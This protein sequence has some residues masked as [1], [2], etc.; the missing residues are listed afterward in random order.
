MRDPF[1]TEMLAQ[2]FELPEPNFLL[3][4]QSL[5]WHNGRPYLIRQCYDLMEGR[6]EGFVSMDALDKPSVWPENV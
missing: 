4:P 1:V 3:G 6:W 2:G 5:A